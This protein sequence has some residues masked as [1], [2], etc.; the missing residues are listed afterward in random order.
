MKNLNY[1]FLLGLLSVITFCISSCSDDDDK[2]VPTGNSSIVG[3]WEVT[4]Q[5]INGHTG[6]VRIE[7]NSNKKGSMTVTYA[8]GTDSDSYNF[9]YVLKEE[10]DGD[11]YLSII[12]TGTKYLIYPGGEYKITIYPTRLEWGNY[13]YTRK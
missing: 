6:D 1:L 10:N 7:F 11:M 2:K 13:K 4:D 5:K 8:D 12:W 3:I 9:E